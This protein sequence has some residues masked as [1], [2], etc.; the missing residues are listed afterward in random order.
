MNDN[1]YVIAKQDIDYSMYLVTDR[2]IMTT[3]TLSEAVE[4][5]VLGGCTM[6]QLREK[7]VSTYDYYLL[8]KEIKAITDK[9]RVPLIINDR[10]DVALAVDAA[11][12][13]L[14][15]SDMPASIARKIIGNDMIL[16][17]SATT[18]EEA[19]EA[20]NDGADYLGIGAIFPT[21]TKT[22][23]K[24]VTMQELKEIRSRISIP[25]VAI[26]GINKNNAGQLTETG[27]DGLAIVSAI[28]GQPDIR[29]AATELKSVFVKGVATY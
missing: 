9:Y 11:G 18:K 5:A 17:V 8:A 20:V 13:H 2:A 29:A 3:A 21:D 23:A 19:E 7:A 26:G 1:K 24:I 4:E 25:I 12:V 22:D 27:I 10:I 28:I 6:I 15:Q 16:G 14:G